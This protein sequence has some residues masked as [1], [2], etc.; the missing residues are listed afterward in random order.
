MDTVPEDISM[1]T[2]KHIL[3]ATDF[4]DAS[5]RA[6]ELACALATESGAHLTVVHVSEI[7][8]YSETGPIPYEVVAPHV[9]SAQAQ[10]DAALAP[11]RRTCLGAKGLVKV[12][13]PSEHILAVARET[14][15]DLVVV[16]THGRRGIAHAFMG[17]VAERVVRTSPVPVLTVRSHPAS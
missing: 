12:G 1:A 6:I 15:A 5:A 10:L 13:V 3:V 11:I 2:F 14:G 7:P 4:S 17:S 16:G 9:E 8:G